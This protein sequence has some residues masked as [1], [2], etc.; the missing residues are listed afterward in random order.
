MVKCCT[1]SLSIVLLFGDHIDQDSSG[2][3]LLQTKITGICRQIVQL[4]YR[5]GETNDRA[6][7]RSDDVPHERRFAELEA[8]WMADIFELED[9]SSVYQSISVTVTMDNNTVFALTRLGQCLV[10]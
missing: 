5:W 8:N 4:E 2:K 10:D 3:E 7:T 9:S 6:L 1:S